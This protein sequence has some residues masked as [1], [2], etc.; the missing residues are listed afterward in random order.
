MS[1]SVYLT[2][3]GPASGKSIVALGLAELLSRRVSRFGFF[4][5]IVQ[6]IPD[7]DIELI[8]TRYRLADNQVGFAFTADELRGL[9]SGSREVADAGMAQAVAAYK[10]LEARCDI[11]VIEGTDFTGPSSP[12]EFDFNARVAG[13]LGAPVVAVINGHDRGVK[14]ISETVRVSEETLAGQGDTVLALI[15]NRVAPSMLDDVQTALAGRSADAPPAW[16]LPEDDGL[17]H[18][19]LA[20]LGDALGAELVAGEPDDMTREVRHVKVA[21]MSVSNLLDHVEDG[22]VFIAPGDRPDVLVTAALTRHSGAYP[23]VAG[24][25]L[26]GGLRP[27][28]RI[29]GLI[30]GLGDGGK[31]LPM[32]AVGDDTFTTATAAGQVEGAITPGNER[33]IAAAL[34]LFEAHV[35]LT[36]L[37]QRVQLAR[38]TVVTPVMFQYELIER[39]KQAAAR[40]VLPEGTDDRILEAAERLLR[41]KVCQLTLLGQEAAVRQRISELGLALDDVP[42]IDPLTSTWLEAFAERYRELRAHKGVTI[43]Q[44]RDTMTDVSFFGTMMVLTGLVDGM[45][46]GA[47]H[48]TAHTIRPALEL[49]RTRP[50]TSIV[51]SVFLMLLADR[52]LV[53]GDCAIN[54]DPNAA[55]LADIAI[56]SAA[57]AELFGIE[58]RVAMLSYSTGASGSGADVDKVRAATERARSLRPDLMI[59]GPI[60]YDAAVDAGVARTKMPDSEVAGQATV[61]IFPDLNTGNNTYKAVQRSA[62]AVAVGP[63]LQGLNKPVNDLS[64]GATVTDIV[65]TVA[66]TAIQARGDAG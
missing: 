13:H 35:D 18:P 45:V 38:S 46:S 64:R 66:I 54:P 26:S 4:R 65:N 8:R 21:A 2:A 56:S 9:V 59:E 44:A 40:V 62:D 60:Q 17:R 34:G 24:V 32:L 11:V 39:A 7:N 28:V 12:L 57:T 27:D 63:V 36:R 31:P 1:R 20:E 10:E 43:D 61:F 47:V 52:V 49:I 41:R 16:A 25:L 22:T 55:Q 14:A 53:Y 6:A 15:V 48:T 5:P 29:A 50:D 23:S 30:N 58:P 19:S 33:K 51:S 42:I 37:E 3:M